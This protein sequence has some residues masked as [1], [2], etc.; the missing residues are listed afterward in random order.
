MKPIVHELENEYGNDI[1]FVYLDIDNPNT[2]DAR[3]KYNFRYQPHF[4][5]VDENGEVIEEWLGYNSP[6]VF[7]ESFAQ[8]LN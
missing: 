7:E 1:E 2:L 6:N 3:Q 8:I 4:I 5:L